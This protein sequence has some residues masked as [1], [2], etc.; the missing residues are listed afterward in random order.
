MSV[1]PSEQWEKLNSLLLLCI[2]V[3]GFFPCVF[4][5]RREHAG[6]EYFFKKSHAALLQWTSSLHHLLMSRTSPK[7][8]LGIFIMPVLL[9][10][11][12]WYCSPQVPYV[13]SAFVRPK[14]LHWGMTMPNDNRAAKVSVFLSLKGQVLSCT[15]RMEWTTQK[16]SEK[17]IFCWFVFGMRYLKAQLPLELPVKML[18]EVLAVHLCT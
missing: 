1:K 13:P 3:Q 16:Q 18:L 11:T 9:S 12:C 2:S 4:L 17:M 6:Q 5:L 7:E 14:Q 8:L 10:S 15:G